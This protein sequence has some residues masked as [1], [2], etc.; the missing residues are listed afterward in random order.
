M[1]K[2]NRKTLIE[3]FA[4][5]EMPTQEAFADLIDS[6]VNIVDDGFDKTATDGMKVA[7]L[8]SNGKLV[9]FYDEITVRQPLWSIAFSMAGYGGGDATRKNLNFFHGDNRSAAL[10]LSCAAPFGAA[11]EGGEDGRIR[12]GI[13][14]SA[15]DR[16]LDVG[17]VIA[18]EGRT[19]REGK[20]PVRADGQWHPII[21]GLDG[22]QAFEIMAGV[23]KKN[24][25]R[26]ALLHAF[27]LSVFKSPKG[28]ITC[29]QARYSSKCDQIELRWA[30]ETHSYSLEMRTRCNFEQTAGEEIYVRYHVTQ[31][32]FDPF[33]EGSAGKAPASS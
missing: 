15:P 14:R 9:S 28:N 25:G 23:G 20:N 26:Y 17:G 13:N 10:T 27:A 11:G 16:E 5:G 22:C 3:N 32:W 7:Q 33:M 2:R 30:G 6:S 18:S 1:T 19:G 31:L 24:T 12:I 29:H 21:Q 8:G 4:D